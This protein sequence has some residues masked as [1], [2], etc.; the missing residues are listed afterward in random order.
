[1]KKC[2]ISN[3]EKR[4]MEEERERGYFEDQLWRRVTERNK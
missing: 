4:S 1:M 2:L 3:R